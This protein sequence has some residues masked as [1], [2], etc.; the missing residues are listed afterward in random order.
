MRCLYVCVHSIHMLGQ[1]HRVVCIIVQFSILLTF[2]LN[3]LWGWVTKKVEREG[4]FFVKA[5]RS[6][7]RYIYTIFSSAIA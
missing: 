4:F 5:I 1:G 7:H 6:M 2:L 3:Y